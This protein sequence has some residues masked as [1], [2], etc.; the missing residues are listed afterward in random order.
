MLFIV[1]ELLSG[2]DSALR[3]R[4]TVSC[5]DVG[6]WRR[7]GPL[8]QDYLQVRINPD[9]V[10]PDMEGLH[11]FTEYLSESLEPES[12]FALLA[13]PST[14]GFLKLSRPCCYVFPGGR[15]DAAFFAVNGFN[16]LV[17]GGADTRSCFWKLVRH[18]DR[19]DSVLVTHAGVDNLPGIT[20]LLQR[21]VAETEVAETEEAA[22]AHAEDDG[23]PDWINQKNLVSPE[24][25]VVF[26][27]VPERL[28]S[29]P[30]DTGELRSCDQAALALQLLHRLGIKPQPLSRADAPAIEPVILFQ[31]MG[32]GRLELYPLNP[33][34]GS[35]TL[36]AFMQAWPSSVPRETG[37]GLPLPCL[38]SICALLVWHPSSPAEKIIRIL[39]PG[40]TPQNLILDALDKLQHLEFLKHAAVCLSDLAALKTA[41]KQPRRA[42]SRESLKSQTKNSR[43][44]P[45]RQDVKKQEVKTKAAGDAAPRHGEDKMK[46]AQPKLPRHGEDKMKDADAKPK[47]PKVTSNPKK[48][49][50]K[51]EKNEKIAVVKKEESTEKKRE[52]VKK[53]NFS[54]NPK[55][56]LRP[57]PRKEVKMEV[58][59]EEETEVKMMVKKAEEKTEVTMEEKKA[60]GKEGRKDVK[61]EV[62]MVK[63]A[64]EK[65]AVK[66]KRFFFCT[67][68]A[69]LPGS[70]AAMLDGPPTSRP[71]SQQAAARFVGTLPELTGLY[72]AQN[73]LQQAG[74]P[75]SP[76]HHEHRVIRR[77]RRTGGPGGTG[78]RSSGTAAPQVTLIPTFDSLAMHRWY[79]ETR[80]RQRALGL[81][82]LG[83]NSTVAMQDETF[84]ACKVE[85]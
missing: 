1:R 74:R 16:V 24:I 80:D 52:G 72:L 77:R 23:P 53:E 37:A 58:K 3:P 39:F 36:H 59:T 66:M 19:V 47:L 60:A 49:S 67:K 40:C 9:P 62:K 45:P 57:E 70:G 12:P 14:V 51:D 41:E 2:V 25:G 5:P 61:T 81:T 82:V 42:E 64:E 21:K 46:D 4:L 10:L 38:V 79:Q 71:A 43:D 65:T 54:R 85:F 55:P 30:A 7:A 18:L 29:E 35:K 75:Q 68:N 22:A 34:S 69:H 31:K 32:V 78:G 11:E 20:S 48:D 44:R 73:P 33:V 56:D 84:P 15:G 8:Q 28:K 50:S 17:N 63:K 76:H 13:A 83:S 27:N 26:L 6:V